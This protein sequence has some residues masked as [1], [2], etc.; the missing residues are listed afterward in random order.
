MEVFENENYIKAVR[1]FNLPDGSCTFEYGKIKTNVKIE[2]TGFFAQTH[3]DAYEV[4]PHPAPRRQY[5]VTLKGKLQFKV[6]NG[7]TFIIEP[8]I[9]LIA[10]DTNGVGHTWELIDGEKWERLYIALKGDT[11]FII[12]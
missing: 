2:S 4:V 1:L 9:I 5:V 10:E 7:D 8:G 6:T 11:H 12:D 3:V